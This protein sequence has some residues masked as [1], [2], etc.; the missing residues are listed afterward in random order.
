[1]ISDAGA[2]RRLD[3]GDD[4]PKKWLDSMEEEAGEAD[5]LLAE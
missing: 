2:P 3:G 4:D 1:M 5:S